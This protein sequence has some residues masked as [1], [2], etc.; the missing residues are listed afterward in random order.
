MYLTAQAALASSGEGGKGEGHDV[1]AMTDRIAD[2]RVDPELKLD[3]EPELLMQASSE[4]VIESEAET[5]TSPWSV[6]WNCP[7]KA[8]TEAL[9][10]LERLEGM[11]LEVGPRE[12]TAVLLACS[13]D[14][15]ASAAVKVLRY[16]RGLFLGILVFFVSSH[17]HS[18][19]AF[20]G[21]SRSLLHTSRVSRIYVFFR[22]LKVFSNLAHILRWPSCC[23]FRAAEFLGSHPFRSFRMP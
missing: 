9:H 5:W 1:A 8:A 15:A 22:S 4:R 21:H 20:S 16:V 3:I 6:L 11:G 10:A 2:D 23:G 7:G 18:I 12:H 14:G 19:F 13:G 17:F